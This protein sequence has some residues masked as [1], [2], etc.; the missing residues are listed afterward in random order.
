[1]R[2]K[3]QFQENNNG[4][5]PEAQTVLMGIF[6]IS[7]I[8]KWQSPYHFEMSHSDSSWINLRQNCRFEMIKPYPFEMMDDALFEMIDLISKWFAP[9]SFRND[10]MLF[11]SIWRMTVSSK[12]RWPTF[13]N[14]DKGLL[15]LC[16][17]SEWQ[18]YL[19]SFKN[20]FAAKKI[21]ISKRQQPQKSIETLSFQKDRRFL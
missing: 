5:H 19:L 3:Y 17:L 21:V 4:L 20:D 18:S 2:V 1:M 10:G 14:E 15:A 13:W 16:L 7:V 12:C 11:S 6:K 8:S 9:L